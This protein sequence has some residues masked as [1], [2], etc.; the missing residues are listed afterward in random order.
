MSILLPHVLKTLLLFFERERETE[1]ERER[2]SRSQG[3]AE[4]EMERLLSR[5]HI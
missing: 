4:E 1:R 2:D 3:G 5:L